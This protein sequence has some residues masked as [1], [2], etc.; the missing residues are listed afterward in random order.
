MELGHRA[1]GFMPFHQFNT[2]DL[3]LRNVITESQLNDS[4]FN[5]S[6]SMARQLVELYRI[7]KQDMFILISF[8]GCEAMM[9]ETAMLAKEK[10]HKIMAVVSKALSEITESTHPSKKKLT[11]LAD[12][13][14][15]NHAQ[16]NDAILDVDDIH[17][18]NQLG[19]ITGN[20]IAQMLTAEIYRY[21]TEKEL[22]CPILLSS[23]IQGADDHNRTLAEKYLGRWN[24]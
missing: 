7:E 11:D 15:D 4:N 1:G 16:I 2:R 12:L 13:V 6:L 20:V 8:S 22:E 21:L 18:M 5:Q 3:V 10:G 17:K 19:T 9:V 24:S 23:N 14:L